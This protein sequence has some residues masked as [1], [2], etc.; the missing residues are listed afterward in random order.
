MKFKPKKAG[1]VAPSQTATPTST[2]SAR[3]FAVP[4]LPSTAGVSGKPRSSVDSAPASSAPRQPSASPISPTAP[5]HRLPSASSAPSTDSAPV[6]TPSTSSGQRQNA[7]ITPSPSP[8]PSATM[9]APSRSASVSRRSTTPSARVNG[10]LALLAAAENANVPLHIPASMDRKKRREAALAAKEAAANTTA[11]GQGVLS[12][13]VVEGAPQEAAGDSGQADESGDGNAGASQSANGTSKKTAPK[14]SV[15][16]M[17]P[18]LH[19]AKT[20]S[21]ATAP[22]GEAAHDDTSIEAIAKR[23]VADLISPPPFSRDGNAEAGPSSQPLV[24]APPVVK[25]KPIRVRKRKAAEVQVDYTDKAG[26]ADGAIAGSGSEDDG[27]SGEEYV[28]EKKGKKRRV[29]S[30]KGKGKANGQTTGKGKGKGKGK[31]VDNGEEGGGGD[32]ANDAQKDGDENEDEDAD[33]EG[34]G[35]TKRVRMSDHPAL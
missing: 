16:G 1:A 13:S 31:A 28:G 6:P 24:A 11:N 14:I 7:R 10:K 32:E 4:S 30:G 22:D 25:R 12:E 18:T 8:V 15:A 9:R 21:A 29:A 5:T 35:N 33:M 2:G 17:P 27:P 26:S 19:T 3:K 20:H 23:A 34:D